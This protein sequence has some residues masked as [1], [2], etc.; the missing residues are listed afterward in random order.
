MRINISSD[1]SFNALK[2]LI[3]E[4][5]NNSID[6]IDNF[7]MNNKL[8]NEIRNANF[9]SN[10]RYLVDESCKCRN[11]ISVLKKRSNEKFIRERSELF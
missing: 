7:K 5:I 3:D 9:N 6:V 4:K 1:S 11:V 8:D 2:S 10:I